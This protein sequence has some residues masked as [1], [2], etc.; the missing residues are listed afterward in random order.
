MYSN[1]SHFLSSKLYV[2]PIPDHLQFLADFLLKILETDAAQTANKLLAAQ[3]EGGV[4]KILKSEAQI[5]VWLEISIKNQGNL[6]HKKSA[7][8]STRRSQ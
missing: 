2:S 5:E 4:V 8:I 1:L 3:T 6:D 7:Q